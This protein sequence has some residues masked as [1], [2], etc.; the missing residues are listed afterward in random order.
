MLCYQSPFIHVVNPCCHHRNISLH[1]TLYFFLS[2]PK[3]QQLCA[4]SQAERNRRVSGLQMAIASGNLT[5]CYW[6]WLGIVDLPIKNGDFPLLCGCLPEGRKNDHVSFGLQLHSLAIQRVP[7]GF[8]STYGIPSGRSGW[9]HWKFQWFAPKWR[10]QNR[11]SKGTR[12][13]W[14]RKSI[15]QPQYQKW[16]NPVPKPSYGRYLWVL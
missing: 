9:K 13:W 5:V 1:R 8:S 15:P 3:V 6:K 16:R 12:K 10:R 14:S 2:F 7:L 4:A 11:D